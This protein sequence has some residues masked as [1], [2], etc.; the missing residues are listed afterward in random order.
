MKTTQATR[1]STKGTSRSISCVGDSAFAPRPARPET[2][3][4]KRP[5]PKTVNGAVSQR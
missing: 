4:R 5:M 2:R 1:F 3:K